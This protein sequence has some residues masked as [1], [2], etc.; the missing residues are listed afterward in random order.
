[1]QILNPNIDLNSVHFLLQN[2]PYLQ[3]SEVH[4]AISGLLVNCLVF[5]YLEYVI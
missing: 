4:L 3:K 1:M 5:K 2:F